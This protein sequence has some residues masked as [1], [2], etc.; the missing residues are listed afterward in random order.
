M[1]RRAVAPVVGVVLLVGVTVV[2]ATIVGAFAIGIGD[3]GTAPEAA[4]TADRDGNELTLTHHSGDA[5]DVTE[6]TVRIS[7]DGEPLEKQPDVP[8]VGTDGFNGTPSGPF[9]PESD[10]QWTAGETASLTI[11][12]TTNAPQPTAGSQVTVKIY[13]ENEPVATART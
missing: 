12:S 9:N 6:L 7:V 11:A 10:P 8:F 5:L 3:S 1:S 4:I 2:L 13:S